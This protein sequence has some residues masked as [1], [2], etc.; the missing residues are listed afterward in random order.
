MRNYDLTFIDND[1]LYQHVKETVEKYRFHI[2]L[3]RF[4]KNL[5]DPIKL[6]FDSKVYN[7][8]IEDVIDTEIIRQ[9]TIIL[10]IFIKIFFVIWVMVGQFPK[11]AMT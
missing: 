4:N 2:D 9:I 1:D 5:I 10:D 8:S 11:Q 6:T 7:K 3:A